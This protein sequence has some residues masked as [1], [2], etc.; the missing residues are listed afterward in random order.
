MA[1][2]RTRTRALAVDKPSLVE[3]AI[4]FRMDDDSARSGEMAARKQRYAKYRQWRAG[5]VKR[6]WD[7][8]SDVGLPD[9]M[10]AVLRTQ[11]T[12]YNAAIATRP[13][14]VSKASDKKDLEAQGKLDNILDF[15]AFVENGEDWL[16]DL[17]ESFVIDG[18]FTA[19]IPWVKE[20]RET[21]QVYT[22]PPIP[23]GISP[24]DL[25]VQII[26][27]TLGPALVGLVPRGK[28]IDAWDFDVTLREGAG[29]EEVQISF[30]TTDSGSLEIHVRRDALIFDGP[31]I[32]VKDREDV[33]HPPHVTNLQIPGPSNPGGSPHVILVDREVGVEEIRRGMEDGFYDSLT[34]E[35][36]D[37]IFASAKQTEVSGEKEQRMAIQGNTNPIPPSVAEH[38]T[39]T[40]LLVFDTI[41]AGGKTEDVVYWI[42]EDPKVLLRVRR[43]MEVY[44][45]PVP[46][47]P[48]AEKQFIPVKGSRTGIGLP[49][50][51]EAMHD[52]QKQLYDQSIDQGSMSLSPFFFYRPSSSMDA[53]VIRLWPGEGYPLTDPVRDVHF[54]ALPPQGQ[55]YAM[56]MLAML[57]KKEEQVTAIGDFQLGR[58]PQGKASALRT[59]AGM[60]MIAAQGEARPE[61]ILRRFF[62]GLAD[63]WRQM[64]RLNRTMLSREKV[65]RIA[66]S[67]N[68]G[69]EPYQTVK[70]G[71]INADF[72]FEFSANVFNTSRQNLQMALGTLIPTLLGPLGF[73][74]GVTGIKTI[75]QL[76]RDLVKSWGL[77]PEKYLD[78]PAGGAVLTAEEAL[79]EIIDGRLPRGVPVEGFQAHL[80]KLMQFSQSPEFGFLKPEV[81][82][83][84]QKWLQ[85]VQGMLVAQQ[86]M[87]AVAQAADGSSQGG[88]GSSQ[89]GNIG[90]G[91]PGEMERS[92][93]LQKNELADETLP[94]SGGGGAK[95]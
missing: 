68:P 50:I 56:N 83:I 24:P 27:K 75:Y 35:E 90:T 85:I 39:V 3:R 36:F 91:N 37:K 93:P 2:K 82:P 79:A 8:A 46:R 54:P 20:T 86:Q 13:T 61:R 1:E 32:I 95:T 43:L 15:Q 73:Q 5:G 23:D 38:R 65:F 26:A 28:K 12:L 9:V 31:K 22:A 18:H 78:N 87:V 49:E 11:D 41:V 57:E 59:V 42:V 58:V 29:T 77:D 48:F 30:Y 63:I 70:P 80:D 14:I 69:E 62:S 64:H 53:G 92:A 88:K 34:R 81:V 33:L 25:F 89:P 71:E 47:R 74:A 55:A 94:T 52:I 60:N 6:P 17:S 66:R 16:D 76:Y 7:N 10:T 72:D 84:F 44:P 40:R 51:V 45:G 67:L 4:K 21:L 19:F